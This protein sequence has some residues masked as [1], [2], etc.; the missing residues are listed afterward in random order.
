MIYVLLLLEVVYMVSIDR[1]SVDKAERDE[2][3]W[4]VSG[5]LWP[6]TM[7]FTVKPGDCTGAA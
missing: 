2:R 1:V 4:Q 7:S 6:E 5:L 3:S